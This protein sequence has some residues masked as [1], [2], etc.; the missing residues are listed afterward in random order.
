MNENDLPIEQIKKLKK[1]QSFYLMHQ[2]Y[3]FLD[4]SV[5]ERALSHIYL[6]YLFNVDLEK[7]SLKEK[8]EIFPL[9]YCKLVNLS[10]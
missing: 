1:I 10:L 4:H 7:V 2:Q 8:F 6:K 5:L 3:I 9:K